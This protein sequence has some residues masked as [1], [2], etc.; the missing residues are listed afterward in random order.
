MIQE[1]IPVDGEVTPAISDVPIFLEDGTKE[2]VDILEFRFD[3]FFYV[4]KNINPGEVK[5]YPLTHKIALDINKV[6]ISKGMKGV[7]LSA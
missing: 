4:C 3:R 5:Q 6:L 1:I 7:N 2:F